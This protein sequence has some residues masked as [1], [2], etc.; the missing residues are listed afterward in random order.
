MLH[1][2]KTHAPDEV[3]KK[4]ID[5]VN[6]SWLQ[7][8]KAFEHRKTILKLFSEFCSYPE[9]FVSKVL[10]RF[11][12]FLFSRKCSSTSAFISVREANLLQSRKS[13]SEI[14]TVSQL[15]F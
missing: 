12:M 3:W 13:Q 9:S 10:V 15:K 1:N 5:R 6:I 14:E 11:L 4:F 8:T 7:M 2:I